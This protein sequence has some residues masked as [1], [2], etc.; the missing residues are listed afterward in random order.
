VIGFGTP[1]L[2]W[3]AALV[4][5]PLLIH[6]LNRRRYVVKPFAAMAFLQ[7]AFAKRRRRLRMEN[8]LLLLLRCLV[9]LLAALAMALPFVSSDSPLAALSG[10]RRDVVLVVDRSGSTD[11]A[12][13]GSSR[14][15]DRALELVRRPPVT[16]SRSSRRAPRSCS[17]RPS[18]RRR[19]WPS[20]PSTKACPSQVGWPIW[21][22]PC[23]SSAIVCDRPPRVASTSRS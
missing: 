7:Q 15:S 14:L 6:L 23:A 21:S 18:A 3:G 2:L 22:P 4:G 5:V 8:L 10:G 9:V 17:P 20:P 12:L 11:L 1:L 16:P 19:R 13:D